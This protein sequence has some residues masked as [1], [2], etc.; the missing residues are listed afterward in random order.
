MVIRRFAV[1]QAVCDARRE[2]FGLGDERRDMWDLFTLAAWFVFFAI[3]LMPEL[4]FYGIRE[5]AQ[6]RSSTAL[7]NSSAII[8]LGFAAYLGLFAFRRCR[9]SGAGRYIAQG[10]ALEVGLIA[11]VAFLELPARG[12]IFQSRTLV[13]VL[14]ALNE[15][16]DRYLQAVVLFVGSSKLLAWAYLLSL[17]IRYHA[18]GNRNVFAEVPSLFPS[19]HRVA[20]QDPPAAVDPSRIPGEFAPPELDADTRGESAPPRREVAGK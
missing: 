11:L 6:V 20:A 16:P 7:V 8:T 5:L 1:P 13:T 12:A 18:F 9:E 3:G 10:K 4:A 14:L 2:N 17:M 15:I 19:M